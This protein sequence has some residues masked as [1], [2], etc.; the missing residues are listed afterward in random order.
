MA[1]DRGLVGGLLL[2]SHGG[3]CSFLLVSELPGCLQVH[4]VVALV[5]FLL[6][7]LGC[8]RLHIHVSHQLWEIAGSVCRR[9]SEEVPAQWARRCAGRLRP[10]LRLGC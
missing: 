6:S 1:Q 10:S 2:R 4:I 9:S 3:D 5:C 7:R 8:S